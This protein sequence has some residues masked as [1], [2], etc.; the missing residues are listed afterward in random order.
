[1][2]IGRAGTLPWP[3]L[4]SEM[5]YFARVTQRPLLPP[6]NQSSPSSSSIK[7]KVNA[8]IMGR[9]TWE[10]IPQAYRPLKKR[11]NVIISRKKP[12]EVDGVREGDDQVLVASSLEEGVRGLMQRFNTDKHSDERS[13]KGGADD[14]EELGRVFVIG[15]AE[16]Y[17]AAL[18]LPIKRGT[19]RAEQW[20]Q[21]ILWT[22]VQTDFECD[23]FF[24]VDLEKLSSGDKSEWIK[25]TNEDLEEWTGEKGLGELKDENG[26]EYQVCMLERR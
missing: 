3:S 7:K 18:N 9:K 19:E 2:G 20:V 12:S 8:I 10:S 17:R 6:S 11:F 23:T 26:V 16:I 21:R 1:M 5:A 22:R 24:P 13:G 25:K 4:P 15:G 14:K